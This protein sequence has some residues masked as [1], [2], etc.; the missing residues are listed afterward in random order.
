MFCVFSVVI[1][2]VND[3]EKDLQ[4]NGIIGDTVSLTLWCT[5]FPYVGGLKLGEIGEKC[6][7]FLP[8]G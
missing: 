5:V 1:K 6:R 7:F 8:L 4:M 3:A 2:K